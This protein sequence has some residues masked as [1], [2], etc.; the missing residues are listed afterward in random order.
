MHWFSSKKR[1]N[2]IENFFFTLIL[3]WYFY[4]KKINVMQHN[5]AKMWLNAMYDNALI[6]FQIGLKINIK[7]MHWWSRSALWVHSLLV[8]SSSF[9]IHR[10][11]PSISAYRSIHSL[12]IL[13]CS[14]SV[15]W[16]IHY[17][18]RKVHSL[19]VH[20]VFSLYV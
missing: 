11:V 14:L 2:L 17:F 20:K 3:H 10:V 6:L 8:Q 1:S 12:Y 5:V 19:S 13:F 9:N 18:Y 4:G 15:E 16:S 7:S